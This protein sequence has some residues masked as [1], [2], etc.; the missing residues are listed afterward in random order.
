MYAPHTRCRACGAQA[1]E[2]Y[3]DLGVQAPANA[4]R[5][6]DQ[7]GTPEFVAPLSVSWC[8]ACGLSQLDQVVDP[9]ILYTDYPFRAGTS[10]MWQAHCARL[11]TA[12][13]SPGRKF[14]IDIG[15]NDGTLL[16]EAASR[17]WKVL[18]VDPSP[19][20]TTL[21]TLDILWSSG[22]A[23]RIAR[24]HGQAEVVTATNV[25][26]HV[27]DAKD[28]LEGVALILKPEGLCLIECPHIF[29]LLE[30]VA[31]DTIYHEHLSYW[32]LRPLELLAESVGL[33][34]IDVRMFPD[35][36]GGTMRYVLTTGEAR[37]TVKTSVTGLRIL[38]QGHFQKGL[39]PYREFAT[40]VQ[41]TRERFWHWLE[42]DQRA[43]ALASADP[44]YRI[45]GY[46]ASAK[47]N[48]LLQ[49]VG[50]D[51]HQIARI[52]D[53]T[54][55]KWGLLTPGTHIPITAA[56]DLTEPDV[57]VL[58]SW[59]NATDLKAKAKDHG[60]R[61]IFFLPHPPHFEDA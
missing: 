55:A 3:L 7:A 31:F 58:L 37:A 10:Q 20:D 14:L 18:G 56:D 42:V 59:N 50:A 11:M 40:A 8:A 24:L 21:P 25:F 49:Y 17:G 1:L 34:V 43:K 45:W 9:Q 26:G 51:V 54:A 15:S 2:R 53:D 44:T 6:P 30:N 48:V 28:F 16:G 32:S 36:H 35:L 61:G 52:V 4:M 41:D 47:G 60:F 12:L 19:G 46:G 57:L 22:V 27:D 38:E 5:R 33:K 23:R 39:A 13:E 29:P